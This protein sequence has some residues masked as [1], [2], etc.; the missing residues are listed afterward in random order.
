MSDLSSASGDLKCNINTLFDT[1]N[2]MVDV[3]RNL[4]NLCGNI[5]GQNIP[6]F[7]P[8]SRL[9][10]QNPYGANPYAQQPQYQSANYGYGYGNIGTNNMYATEYQNG[11][12]P[13]ISNPSY[14]M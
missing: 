6:A 9:T 4:G 3:G 8:N 2:S 12:Y 14:G 1:M 5:T 13:G 11:G 10:N 7:D